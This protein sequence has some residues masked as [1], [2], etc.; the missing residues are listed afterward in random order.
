MDVPKDIQQQLAVP[1]WDAPMAIT[2]YIGRLPPPP[3]IAMLEPVVKAIHASKKPVRHASSTLSM[4]CMLPRHKPATR[5]VARPQGHNQGYMWSV[6]PHLL[7]YCVHIITA[8]N[9]VER[10][11]P[12]SKPLVL[13]TM[14]MCIHDDVP[15]L[16]DLS[17]QIIYCGGGCIDSR[18]ELREFARRIGAPL[19][20]T[21]MGLGT[22][23]TDDPQSLGMLGMHGTV[24]ANYSIDQV[25]TMEKM[26]QE[27]GGRLHQS[28]WCHW[29]AC[30][31]SCMPT[32]QLTRSAPWG[33]CGRR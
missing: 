22:F 2:G 21:L 12:T 8:G 10:S 19:T 28:T 23:P 15:Y 32:T 24:Y 1:D 5:A 31:E 20:S 11:L 29:G 14:S 6:Y 16:F 30:T 13:D 33:R 25:S 26:W 3:D 4:F 17:L 7:Q 9:P 18:D 27:A